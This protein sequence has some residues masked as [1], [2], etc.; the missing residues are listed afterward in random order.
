MLLKNNLLPLPVTELLRFIGRSARRVS[1]PNNTNLRAYIHVYG[2]GEK[3]R[4]QLTGF[5]WGWRII[6]FAEKCSLDWHQRKITY[7]RSQADVSVI[8]PGS[9]ADLERIAISIPR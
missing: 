6:V 5:D 2:G 3:P 1:Y 9:S 7:T 4:S 8:P